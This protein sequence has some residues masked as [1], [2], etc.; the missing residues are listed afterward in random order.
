MVEVVPDVTTEWRHCLIVF[1]TT[2]A[3]SA[4]SLPLEPNLTI[5]NLGQRLYNFI[6]DLSSATLLI[7]SLGHC[8]DNT[9]GEHYQEPSDAKHKC[10]CR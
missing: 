8:V 2:Q 1:K 6:F 7:V 5:G 4:L 9:G 10:C 3:D